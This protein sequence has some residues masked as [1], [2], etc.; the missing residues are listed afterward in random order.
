[1]QHNYSQNAEK[2]GNSHIDV[3]LVPMGSTRD[4]GVW[5]LDRAA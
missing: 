5:I 1:M 3:D 4:T 2:A